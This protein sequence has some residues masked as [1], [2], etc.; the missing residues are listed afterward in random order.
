MLLRELRRVSRRGVV[1]ND[2][3]RGWMPYVATLA[4]THA[5]ARSPITR[6]DGPLS[7]RRSYTLAELDDLAADAG[8]R[9]AH[10]SLTL[11]PRVV[12]TYR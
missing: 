5:F 9:P 6:H 4:S 11:M 3:R 12:T 2:L 10:R 7:L 8:L 1:V